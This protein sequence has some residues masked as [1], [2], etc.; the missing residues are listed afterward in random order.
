M[1]NIIIKNKKLNGS[2]VAI[3]SFND[4]SIISS[5]KS[6]KIVQQKAIKAGCSEPVIIYVPKKNE[7]Y[8]L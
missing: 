5:G 7:T 6:I 1:D 2:Y 4:N 8:M 3:K